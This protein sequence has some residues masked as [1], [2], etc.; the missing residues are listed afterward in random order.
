M[1]QAMTIS[2]PEAGQLLGI[3]RC[4]AYRLCKDGTIK[5]LRLGKKLRVPAA[6]IDNMLQVESD[7][8][9]AK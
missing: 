8:G 4:T 6:V 5:A 3:G 2:V 1:R 9:K 7:R